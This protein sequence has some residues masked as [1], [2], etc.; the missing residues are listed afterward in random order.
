MHIYLF[1]GCCATSF[2]GLFFFLM[3]V[4]DVDDHATVSAIR[5]EGK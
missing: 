1:A 2:H 5:G 3:V 4:V